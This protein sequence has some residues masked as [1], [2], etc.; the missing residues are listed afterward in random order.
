MHQ[1][2][3]THKPKS[4][5][6]KIPLLILAINLLNYCTLAQENNQFISNSFSIFKKNLKTS[7]FELLNKVEEYTMITYGE[8]NIEIS[9]N[10]KFKFNLVGELTK[11]ED[12]DAIYYLRRGHTFDGDPMSICISF[13]KFGNKNQVG[14]MFEEIMLLYDIILK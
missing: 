11:K 12:K 8:N 6:M 9:S 14:F 2:Q 10:P 3:I 5:K 4:F 7:K 13:S 1:N